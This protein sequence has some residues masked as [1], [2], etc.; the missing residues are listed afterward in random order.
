MKN[1]KKVKRYDRLII[2]IFYLLI[3]FISLGSILDSY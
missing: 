3:F 2:S 1:L